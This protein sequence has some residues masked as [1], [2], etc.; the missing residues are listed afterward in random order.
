MTGSTQTNKEFSACHRYAVIADRK[1]RLVVD[2][3]RGCTANEAL[4]QLASLSPR[5][6][7][8]AELRLLGG[9]AVRE[10]AEVLGVSERTVKDDWRVARAWLASRLAPSRN[11]P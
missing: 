7:H 8:V 6:A 10:V 5:Q 9:L 3:I 2:L 1:A 11:G 4:S